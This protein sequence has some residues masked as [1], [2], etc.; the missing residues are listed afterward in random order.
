MN[1]GNC[2]RFPTR[3]LARLAGLMLAAVLAKF[4]W[5][6]IEPRLFNPHAAVHAD[7]LRAETADTFRRDTFLLR[8][9]EPYRMRE[10]P[11]EVT[12]WLK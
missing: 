8:V 2:R 10:V 9:P 5:D 6:G 1:R 4:A 7:D 3:A 12:P 11:R